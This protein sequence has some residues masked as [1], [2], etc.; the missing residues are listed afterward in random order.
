MD[1]RSTALLMVNSSVSVSITF[2]ALRNS[3]SVSPSWVSVERGANS[4]LSFLPVYLFVYK[5]HTYYFIEI[6]IVLNSI[7]TVRPADDDF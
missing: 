3:K 6:I 5:N 1:E 2:C 4:D 7:Y